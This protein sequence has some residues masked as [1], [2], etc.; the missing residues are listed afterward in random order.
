MIFNEELLTD[1]RFAQLNRAQQSNII[2]NHC[3]EIEE[4]IRNA[5]SRLEAERV[6]ASTCLQFEKE[7]PSM[8]VRNALTSRMEELIAKYWNHKE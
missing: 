7:C 2:A 6:L 4:R 3:A 1:N 8:L 5:S